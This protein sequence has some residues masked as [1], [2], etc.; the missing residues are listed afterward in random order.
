MIKITDTINCI[1]HGT[2]TFERKIE[3][4]MVLPISFRCLKETSRRDGSFEHR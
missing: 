1:G 2:V 4:I 3:M